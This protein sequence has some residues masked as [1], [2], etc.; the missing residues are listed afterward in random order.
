MRRFQDFIGRNF[1]MIETRNLA[2]TREKGKKPAISGL[3]LQVG[4]G[5]SCAR[6][7]ANG[8]GKS[9]L[10][11]A[12]VG[13]APILSGSAKVGGIEVQ[14]KNLRKVRALAG[15]VFQNSDDQLFC[16]TVIDDVAFGI[17]NSGVPRECAFETAEIW[18]ER[19]SIQ[20][21]RDCSPNELSEGEKKR[22]AI[23]GVAAMQPEIMLLDEPSAQLDPRGKREL[24][25]LL[26]S[27]KQT[28]II[29]THDMQFAR[30][31]CNTAIV[32]D[33]GKLAARGNIDEILSDAPLLERCSLL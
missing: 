12:L 28:K 6:L 33:R 1:Y 4:N 27:F 21:L 24:A 29:S 5:D 10:L 16:P 8:A 26:N 17:E 25:D 20:N 9:T 32:L 15:L 30:S 19:L 7:G 14:K 3:D 11:L 31:V 23:C 18:L 13:L 22:A 2:A